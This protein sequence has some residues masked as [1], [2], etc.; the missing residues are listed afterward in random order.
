MSIDEL[1]KLH[2]YDI[3]NNRNIDPNI[4]C[5]LA[6]IF[7]EESIDILKY[8]SYTKFSSKFCW[9]NFIFIIKEM[10]YPQ[11]LKGLP[12]LFELLQDINWPIFQEVA[13]ALM[14]FDKKDIIPFMV[15]YLYQAYSEGD[16]MWIS[17]IYMI[18]RI[19]NIQP[20]DFQIGKTCDL[21]HYRDV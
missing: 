18:A 16:G 15:R 17:G 12:C 14:S 6:E 3:Y 7:S 5:E 21:L 9:T 2:E 11:K 19:M 10:K 1:L 4:L 13:A 8:F 20:S